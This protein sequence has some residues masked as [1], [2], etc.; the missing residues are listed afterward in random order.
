VSG[1]PQAN[2]GGL[3]SIGQ[4]AARNIAA[5]LNLSDE[6]VGTIEKAIRDEIQAMSSHFTLAFADMQ[7][8]YEQ[9]LAKVKSTFSFVDANKRV[10]VGT[11]AAVATAGFILGTVVAAAL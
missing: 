9:D 10:V 4:V 1:A 11:L 5:Y 3:M 8:Q 2:P 7:T 6:H